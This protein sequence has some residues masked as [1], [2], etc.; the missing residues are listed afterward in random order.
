M[1]VINMK[2]K[3]TITTKSNIDIYNTIRREWVKNP[4]TLVMGKTSYNRKEKHK[5][6][7]LKDNDLR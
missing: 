7:Y 5:K 6:D 1:K 2:K 3:I 4:A